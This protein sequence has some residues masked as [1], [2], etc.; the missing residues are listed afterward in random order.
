[1]DISRE[2]GLK[3]NLEFRSA[4]FTQADDQD[5]VFGHAVAQLIYDKLPEYDFEPIAIFA[6]DWGWQV[7]LRNDHYPLWIGCGRY[8]EFENGFLCFIE[9]SKPVIRKWFKKIQTQQRVESLATA[10]ECILGAA[11]GTSDMRWWQPSEA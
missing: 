1:M 3:T 10:I 11:P 5:E 9:P 2:V 8:Q 4:A 6:E 7:S